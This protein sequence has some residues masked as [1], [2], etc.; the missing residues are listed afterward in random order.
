[1]GAN[2]PTQA[3]RAL[4][5]G[6]RT[7]RVSPRAPRI[8]TF[9]LLL[10]TFLTS[11]SALTQAL[12]IGA[13]RPASEKLTPEITAQLFPTA[14]GP[15][16]T[17]Q[18]KKNPPVWQATSNG[19]LLGYIAS[20]A[21][22]SNSIGYSGQPLD[23]LVGI[24]PSATI[25]GARLVHHNEPILTLGISSEDIAHYVAAFAGYDLKGPKIEAFSSNTALPPVIARATV[26]TG[27]IRDAILRTARAV[28]L[29]RGIIKTGGSV[30]D[31]ASFSPRTFAE[32][33]A[34]GSLTHTHVTMKDAARLFGT[35]ANPLPDSD[36]TFLDLW[37]AAIDP[38]TIGQNLLGHKEYGRV[39]ASLSNGDAAVLIASSGLHSHRGTNYVSTGTF[40]RIEIIQDDRTVKFKKQDYLRIDHFVLN[41]A[42][43]LNEISIFRLPSQS[44]INLAEPFRIEVSAERE[45][46]DGT[47]ATI[48][49]PLAYALPAAYRLEAAASMPEED[50]LWV[51]AWKRKPVTIALVTLMILLVAASF[52]AQEV[53]V[54]RPKLWQWGRTCFLLCTLFFLGWYAAGQLSV[55][56]VVAFFHALL[57]G[58]RWETFLIEPVIFVL[59]SFV[60]LG[61]LFWGRGFYCGWLCPFG[62]LQE[63]LNEAAKRLG[64]RQ[65]EVPFAIQERLWAIKYTLFVIILGVSFYSMEYALVLAEA[66][67]FKTAMSM[68]FMRAWPFVLF[69][70]ALLVAGLFIERFYCR[71]LCPLGAALGIPAKVKLFDWLHRRPQC[72]RECRFCET[73]CTV[74]AIDTLG[75]INPNECVLCLRCQVIM[76]D[77][78]QCIVLKRRG[79]RAAD[80]SPGAGTKTVGVTARKP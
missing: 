17:I 50:P 15:I 74:G 71:Y 38:P 40:D 19:K 11:P 27:V 34:D 48:H 23:I 3:T 24:S 72:G 4:T 73:Q 39:I 6:Q 52:F 76:N 65:I 55:V 37:V 69:A 75:R 1:M 45:R 7:Q 63:L 41:D 10:L 77:A 13:N 28:A 80:A 30:L 8:Y 42:P 9:V 14:A 79:S 20:T 21:E 56:Q 47:A 58:F 12:E 51:S 5:E 67:P 53:F 32:L 66:E 57:N 62:A 35:V 70:V 59:W 78:T 68:R 2:R 49:L 29:G 60:A 25:T 33:T 18:D 54:R 22:I 43:S 36:E 44:A 61:L 64:V 16:Q 46:P 26:T 31:R